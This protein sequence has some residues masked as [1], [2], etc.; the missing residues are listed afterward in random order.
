MLDFH[1]QEDNLLINFQRVLVIACEKVPRIRTLHIQASRTLLGVE[2]PVFGVPMAG[3]SIS[4]ERVLFGGGRWTIFH[5]DSK[6][7]AKQIEMFCEVSGRARGPLNVA[8]HA[9]MVFGRKTLECQSTGG[10]HLTH[11]GWRA[12]YNLPS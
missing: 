8:L 3:F 4:L 10:F 1:A 6:P 9:G 12:D 7:F 11:C 5:F 2:V